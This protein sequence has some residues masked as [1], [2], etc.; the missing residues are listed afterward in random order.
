MHL[1]KTL[2]RLGV[3]RTFNKKGKEME[4]FISVLITK[5]ASDNCNK[6]E[7]NL[8]IERV[9][10][11]FEATIEKKLSNDYLLVLG[12]P[13]LAERKGIQKKFSSK[14]I[15]VVANEESSVNGLLKYNLKTLFFHRPINSPKNNT[16]HIQKEIKK[17]K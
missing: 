8:I 10:F 3:I 16:D 14:I 11:F 9:N 1:H 7:V 4:T 15:I 5:D 13:N 6:D 12:R 17:I 2:L